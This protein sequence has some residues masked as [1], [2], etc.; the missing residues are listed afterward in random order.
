MAVC[1]QLAGN[2]VQVTPFSPEDC[3]MQGGYIAL[4]SEEYLSMGSAFPPLSIQEG[5]LIGSFI[6]I[7]WAIAWG[8]RMLARQAEDFDDVGKEY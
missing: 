4:T 5:A 1:L 2:G 3:S 6:W 7:A 8:F